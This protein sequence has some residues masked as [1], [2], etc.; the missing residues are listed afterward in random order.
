[1]PYRLR[2]LSAH[3]DKPNEIEEIPLKVRIRPGKEARLEPK[4]LTYLDR[5]RSLQVSGKRAPQ[6]R[7]RFRGDSSVVR[8]PRRF[9]QRVLVKSR[10]VHH[11]R[12]AGEALRKHISYLQR[13]GVG[14]NGEEPTPFGEHCDLDRREV[15]HWVDEWSSDR[16]H[17][18][19]IISPENGGELDLKKY[20]RA[21][22]ARMERDLSTKL[23]W[24]GITHHNT[25]KPHLHLLIRGKD[26]LG[27]DLVIARDYISNGLRNRAQEIATRELGF[28]NQKD[29]AQE[30]ERSINQPRPCR[31]DRALLD[32]AGKERRGVIDS[33]RFSNRESSLFERQKLR[34]L[35][36]LEE[37]GLA[38][39]I[40]YG[41]WKLEDDL[42]GKLRIRATKGDIVKTM[43]LKMRGIDPNAE[44][45]ILDSDRGFSG[46]IKG[47][48]LHKGLSDELFDVKYLIVGAENQRAYYVPFSKYSESFGQECGVGDRV[49]LR[50]GEKET[51]LRSDENI[52]HVASQNGGV[53]DVKKHF[54]S[55]VASKKLPSGVRPEQYVLNH[56]RRVKTLARMGMVKSISPGGW[57]VPSDLVERLKNRRVR[58]IAIDTLER[59]RGHGLG[60][61]L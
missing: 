18:R 5:I 53:Y 10:V 50:M 36:Y 48:V 29:L 47:I 11:Q 28:R 41:L 3:R 43:H 57:E 14:I 8:E 20:G 46:A 21:L 24:V 7:G 1:M 9:F 32:E 17:F 45:N 55:V 19:F 51:L 40:N 34:R 15:T 49:S 59:V 52:F 39:R 33:K 37:I 60:L 35:N 2:N 12:D 22:V 23:E 31:I 13:D 25:D 6:R 38:H 27:S 54:E 44:L 30:V 58:Y 16:H 56:E 4:H 26:E 42:L 61:G